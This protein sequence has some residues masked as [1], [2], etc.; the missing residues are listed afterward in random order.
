MS[1]KQDLLQ[2]F[3]YYNITETGLQGAS[4]FIVNGSLVYNNRKEN[5]FT[6]S[7]TAN[8]ASDKIYAL[9]SPEDFVNSDVL[10]NHAIVEKGFVTMDIIKKQFNKHLSLKF[11]GRNY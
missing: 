7:V 3:Q 5:P 2:Q 10:F 6:A 4:D 1:S 9:G 8:Y 11:T